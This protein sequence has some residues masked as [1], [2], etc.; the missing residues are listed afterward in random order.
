MALAT[1]VCGLSVPNLPIL[2]GV[3]ASE[4]AE[5]DLSY[6]RN[7][8]PIVVDSRIARGQLRST[9][10]T[11]QIGTGPGADRGSIMWDGECYRVMGTK[12]CQVATNGAVTVLGD[13]GG[14][15]WVRMDYSFDRL[16]ILSSGK[17]FYWDKATLK[18]VTDSDLG[19][20]TDVMWIDGFFMFTDGKFVGVTELSD[21][22]EVKPLKYGSAETDPD[23]IT[24]VVRA[25]EE[26]YILGR[27]TIQVFQ[28][29]GGNGFPFANVRGASIQY[30]CISPQAKCL[31]NEAFAFVGSARNEALG[32]FIA[33]QGTAERISTKRIETLLNGVL[34]TAQI[35]VEARN[36]GEE[37]RLLVH[38]P[39]RT[40]MFFAFASRQAGEPVWAEMDPL[41]RHAA[42]TTRGM[43]VALDNKIGLLDPASDRQFGDLIEWRFDVG[44]VYDDSKPFILHS[45][46]IVGLPGRGLGTVFFSMTRDGETYTRESA[47]QIGPLGART[48]RLQW[49]PHTH[50]RR[51]VGLRFRG[52]GLF[53]ASTV[54]YEGE[55]LS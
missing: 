15:G 2:S 46:E 3:F 33:G 11:T 29:V 50:V 28:N 51:Y 54:S 12:L 52:T 7:L 32:V 45:V 22:F 55:P 5:F 20:V 35:E 31:Y 17:L 39:D 49:R 36:Y 42:E 16:A 43:M 25:R 21:P 4:S 6:P 26:A 27:H 53:G 10:G 18:Q 30:G 24:G 41:P 38:L 40:L 23:P 1:G 13:V 47:R 9:A 19:T 14:L 37:R 8:E 34:D 44:M 48:K